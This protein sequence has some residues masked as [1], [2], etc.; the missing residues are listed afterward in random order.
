[1]DMLLSLCHDCGPKRREATGPDLASIACSLIDE[2][3][4]TVQCSL[5]NETKDTVQCDQ[6]VA[7]ADLDTCMTVGQEAINITNHEEQKGEMIKRQRGG[8][9]SPCYHKT[10]SAADDLSMNLISPSLSED[11]KNITMQSYMSVYL[12][13]VCSNVVCSLPDTSVLEDED[14][15]NSLPEALLRDSSYVSDKNAECNENVSGENELVDPPVDVIDREVNTGDGNHSRCISDKPDTNMFSTNSHSSSDTVCISGP[16][17]STVCCTSRSSPLEDLKESENLRVCVDKVEDDRNCVSPLICT[18][19]S[20]KILGLDQTFESLM[21]SPG[22]KMDILS[23]VKDDKRTDSYSL[24]N[25]IVENECSS[26]INFD[27]CDQSSKLL[28][29]LSITKETISEHS[30]D[31]D[32]VHDKTESKLGSPK[33]SSVAL[34]HLSPEAPEFIPS[35]T[36]PSQ[37]YPL[38]GSPVFFTPQG[39]KSQPYRTISPAYPSHRAGFLPRRHRFPLTQIMLK[40]IPV[41]TD[42]SQTGAKYYKFSEAVYTFT[43]NNSSVSDTTTINNSHT[44]YSQAVIKN[45]NEPVLT[46]PKV[47]SRELV[48]VDPDENITWVK[49]YLDR[50]QLLMIILRGLPGSGKSTLARYQYCIRYIFLIVQC[51]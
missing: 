29:S 43:G 16:D 36:K 4:N 46:S 8:T 14:N 5:I 15:V 51:H 1:M 23:S 47:V 10:N 6:E 20:E 13:S 42:E 32:N 12:D 38:E 44:L 17:K 30:V 24:E 49:R 35:F 37:T 34:A 28:E 48:T 27:N 33:D 7:R 11:V 21:E 25:N 22:S 2:T 9:I 41:S 39:P 31:A 3:K 45:G 26:T 19:I 50:G 18:N 40:P